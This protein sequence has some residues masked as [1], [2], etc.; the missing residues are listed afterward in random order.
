MIRALDPLRSVGS[1]T[2]YDYALSNTFLIMAAIRF[3]LY[4]SAVKACAEWKVDHKKKH[5]DR[6]SVAV[7]IHVTFP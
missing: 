2:Y 3:L 4:L 1:Y 7:V 6:T 5:L